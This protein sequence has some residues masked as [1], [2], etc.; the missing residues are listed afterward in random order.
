M[1]SFLLPD[2]GEAMVRRFQNQEGSA[3]QNQ[4]RSDCTQG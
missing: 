3:L 1:I 2:S 4:E